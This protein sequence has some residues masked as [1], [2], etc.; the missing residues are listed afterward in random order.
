MDVADQVNVLGQVPQHALT[1]VGAIAGDDDGVVGEPGGRQFDEFDRQFRA[2]AMVGIG[3]GLLG[4]GLRLLAFGEPLS[5][6]IESCRHGQG[7]DLGGGPE[8][9]DDKDREDNPVMSPTDQGLLAA[10]DQR[11]MVHAGAVEGQASSATKCVIDGPEQS[12]ARCKDGDDES[13]K[14]QREGVEVPGGVAEEAMESRPV[15]VAD[16]STGEDD[17]GDEE[18]P[19]G[20]DP[21]GVD[22]DK[23]RE[24]GIGEDR[25]ELQ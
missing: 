12:G 9:I 14:D 25:A 1:A 21:A 17:F 15:T 3:F 20:K 11:V 7:E 10:G 23:G 4:F 2:C 16:V 5:I 8:G 6:A 24:G 13:G 22:L 18:A 19:L